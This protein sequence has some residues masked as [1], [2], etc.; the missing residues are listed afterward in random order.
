MPGV[1][2]VALSEQASGPAGVAEWN[3]PA[4]LITILA[5]QLQG[6][7]LVLAVA[8]WRSLVAR[9]WMLVVL[10]LAAGFTGLVF[11]DFVLS[12]S[13]LI[14]AACVG[15]LWLDVVASKDVPPSLLCSGVFGASISFAAMMP[16]LVAHPN[17][18]GD[19]W[20]ALSGSPAVE[21]VQWMT[22][23]S[24]L[25]FGSALLIS[26]LFLTSAEGW[27]MR[28]WDKR[29]AFAENDGG[30][31]FAGITLAGL[32][33]FALKIV[34]VGFG[35]LTDRVAP[36]SVTWLTNGLTSFYYLAIYSANARMFAMRKISKLTLA[37]DIVAFAYELG[38]GSKGRFAL[39]I[40]FPI[41]LVAVFQTRR[42]PWWA[43]GSLGVI[44][45]AAVFVV[46]PAMY[47]YRLGLASSKDPTHPSAD[48][49]VNAARSWSDSY[50]EKM[51]T[52]LLSTGPGEQVIAATS[53]VF[54]DVR[55]E[56]RTLE[57]LT[58]FWVPRA[59]WPD[60]PEEMSG[61]EIGK[62]S[63][64]LDPGTNNMS[65]LQTGLG[66]LYVFFGP[67]VRLSLR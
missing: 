40:L 31:T 41:I 5:A 2:E 20:A 50:D 45:L 48:L 23:V 8:A 32:A 62:E 25:S 54:F 46:Y 15:M 61:G 38:S 17:D 64:R 7:A 21:T 24:V 3:V 19:L 51:T 26:R 66:E 57:R 35:Y 1:D 12:R 42:V 65:V 9:A 16:Y 14:V 6:G 52:I 11:D 47:S 29:F 30:F 59:L 63:H 34:F 18:N 44:I 10:L 13:L 28:V 33:A 36:T 39:Y 27:W 37:F 43:A 4:A 56:N 67:W 49:M 53:I 55:H 58:L 60:K 22:L